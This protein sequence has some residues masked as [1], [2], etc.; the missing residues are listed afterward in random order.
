MGL[1]L[2]GKILLIVAGVLFAAAIFMFGT[3][4]TDEDLVSV[5]C[6]VGNSGLVPLVPGLALFLVGRKTS[7][8]DM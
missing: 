2:I 6:Y 1:K 4:P 8:D 5:A 3:N 7:K